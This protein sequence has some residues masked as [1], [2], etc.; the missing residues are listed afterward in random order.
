M[1]NIFEKLLCLVY[2][3]RCACCNQLIESDMQLCEACQENIPYI[4]K[5]CIR[6]GSPTE[7]CNCRVRN[8]LFNG[9][10]GVFENR[11]VAQNGMYAFK[12]REHY[13][14]R[15]FFGSKMAEAFKKNFPDIQADYVC[16]VPML[17]EDKL[18]RG[19]DHSRLLAKEVAKNLGVKYNPNLI[20][21][22][23]K[24]ETQHS[25]K[26]FEERVKN[27]KGAYKV[28][29][30]LDDKVIILVDDIRTTAATLNECAKQLR[31]KSA[32]SVYCVTALVG[33]PQKEEN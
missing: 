26:T 20:K 28:C 2:P 21:K 14:A 22:V 9:S 16:S 31:L 18:K 19:Y 27:V 30:D 23:R 8:Y 29:K 11:G 3:K 17:R 4:R 5:I 32:Q 25:L 13:S 24:T 6:C 12:F 10:V 33:T 1:L 15:E 7:N